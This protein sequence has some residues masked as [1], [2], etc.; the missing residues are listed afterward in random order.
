MV[1]GRVGADELGDDLRA[2]VRGLGL[3]DDFV[4]VD[5]AWPTG[6]VPVTLDP[7]GVPGY[8]ITEHVAW[9]RLAWTPELEA[10]L[11]GAAAVGTGTLSRRAGA[12][13]AV[14]AA[15]RACP[16]VRL[17][18]VNLRRP[19]YTAATV[20]EA[21][22]GATVAKLTADELAVV[23][24]LLGLPNADPA[25]LLTRFPALTGVAVTDGANGA[26]WAGRGGESARAPGVPVQVVDTVGAGDAFAAAFVCGLLAGRPP[27]GVLAGANAYAAEVCRRPGGTPRFAWTPPAAPG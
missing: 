3:A 6:T 26:A 10:L 2:A 16:G 1:V 23:A 5:P 14:A 13:E 27:A 7:A 8:T 4:Q 19:F 21:L 22:G 15:A 24:P 11:R 20:A 25:A 17:A 9:D 12:R 18:D